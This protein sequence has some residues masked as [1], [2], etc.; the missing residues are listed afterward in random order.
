VCRLAKRHAL[1]PWRVAEQCDVL[2]DRAAL[3][4]A[5]GVSEE[6]EKAPREGA[7]DGAMVLE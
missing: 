1:E 4:V 6:G 2:R 7:D 5:I 3:D